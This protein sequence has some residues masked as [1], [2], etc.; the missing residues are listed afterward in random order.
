[1][2]RNPLNFMNVVLVNWTEKTVKRTTAK[3]V[4]KPRIV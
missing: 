3:A 4:F 1:M 2:A